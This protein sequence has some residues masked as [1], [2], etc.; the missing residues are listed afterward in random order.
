MSLAFSDLDKPLF[1][2]AALR[3]WR[4]QRM[5]DDLYALFSRN[6]ASVDLV[7]DGLTFKDVAN[8]CGASGTTTLRQAV[9]RDGLTWPAS[10][11]AFLALARTV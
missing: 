8:R 6:G 9:E 4:L 5:S 10:F 1:I 2:A 3:G 7:A 11:E